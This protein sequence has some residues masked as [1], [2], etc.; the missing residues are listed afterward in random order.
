MSEA[1]ATEP[2]AEDASGFGG[3]EG[4]LTQRALASSEGVVSVAA[5]LLAV[6]GRR[7]RRHV[8]A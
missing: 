8:S 6:G 7:D 3:G 1:A 2:D 5:G 4:G